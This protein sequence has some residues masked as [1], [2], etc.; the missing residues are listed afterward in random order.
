M[1]SFICGVVRFQIGT[2]ARFSDL[3]H[4]SPDTLKVT[5]ATVELEAWQTKTHSAVVVKKKAGPPSALS[6][7]SRARI[8]GR[9]WSPLGASSRLQLVHLLPWP[10]G[11][12]A[13]RTRGPL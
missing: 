11:L 10:R 8:G 7:P 12:G 6:S 2:S 3:Q 4:T 1:D 9:L 13:L 5:S